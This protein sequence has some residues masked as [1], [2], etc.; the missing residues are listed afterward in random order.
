MC[1]YFIVGNK[2]FCFFK[3]RVFDFLDEGTFQGG[4]KFS[5]GKG[6]RLIFQGGADTLEDTLISFLMISGGIEVDYFT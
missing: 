1:S 6:V 5:R 2:I 4:V 3:N